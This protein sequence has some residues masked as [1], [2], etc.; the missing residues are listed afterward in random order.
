MTAIFL[1]VQILSFSLKIEIISKDFNC[2]DS[3]KS[4]SFEQIQFCT[5]SMEPRKRNLRKKIQNVK[6]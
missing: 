1:Q 5:I 4:L 3:L 6:N 2:L